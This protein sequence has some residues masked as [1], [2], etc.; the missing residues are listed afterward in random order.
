VSTADPALAAS[1]CIA[2]GPEL[3]AQDW[4]ET[5]NRGLVN[6]YSREPDCWP[7]GLHPNRPLLATE[8]KVALIR[9]SEV[10]EMEALIGDEAAL[11]TRSEHRP[12]LTSSL[13]AAARW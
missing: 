7:A 12:H 9:G 6:D 8:G 11:S 4:S 1:R 10:L 3:G 13:Q 5:C 2:A